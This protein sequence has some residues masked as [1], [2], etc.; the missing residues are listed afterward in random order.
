MKRFYKSAAAAAN[1]GGV[2]V[3]RLDGKSV[4]TP[5]GRELALPTA[6]LAE[7][8]AAEWA[9]QPVDGKVAPSTMPLTRLAVTGLDR[10][11]DRREQVVDDIC[12]YADSDLLCYRA[13]TPVDLALRQARAWQPAVDW[14]ARRHGV[15]L[16]VL[17]GI[18]HRAQ[19]A[20]SIAACR[21]AVAAHGDLALSALF[22]LTAMLGSVVLALAVS[23]GWMDGVAAY[24]AAEL[25]ALYA[26]EKWGEDSEARGR[27][28]RLRRDATA[29]ATFLAALGPARLTS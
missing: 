7:A 2:F 16:D 21:R 22:N 29:C 4:R 8:I 12:K 9:A 11:A 17:S 27:L 26:I 14:A 18:T 19:S 28:D 1:D 23:D 25:D 20:E 13:E 6:T 3:V 15:R 24:E 10:A 5:L